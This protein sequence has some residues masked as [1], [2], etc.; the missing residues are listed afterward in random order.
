MRRYLLEAYPHLAPLARSTVWSH[1]RKDLKYSFKKMNSKPVA[2][3]RL[4]NPTHAKEVA[5]ILAAAIRERVDIVF[6]DEFHVGKRSPSRYSWVKKGA[7]G[8]I[9]GNPK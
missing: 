3:K 4:L 6:I 9:Y 5:T 2:A 8:F 1:V 7:E